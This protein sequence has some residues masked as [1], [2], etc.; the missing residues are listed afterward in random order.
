MSARSS[1][2]SW[3]PNRPL[4]MLTFASGAPD[5]RTHPPSVVLLLGQV[6]AKQASE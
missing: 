1:V 2:V 5:L 4:H 3:R 6:V